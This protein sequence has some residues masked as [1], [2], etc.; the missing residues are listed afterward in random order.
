MISEM[1]SEQ[2]TDELC[3]KIAATRHRKILPGGHAGFRE[4]YLKDQLRPVGERVYPMIQQSTTQTSS[5]GNAA[6]AEEP[7]KSE[8]SFYQRIANP[9]DAAE[10]M[11]TYLYRS[12]MMGVGTKEAGITIALTCLSER[13]SPLEFNRRY[14]IIQGNISM[15]ADY[16]LA[17]FNSLG[18]KHKIIQRDENAAV[19]ELAWE[20]EKTR[21]SF[22]WEDAQ[23]EPFIYGKKKEIKDNYATP[24][25]RMQML[26]ARCVSDGVR[27]VCPQVNSGVYTPEETVDMLGV[28][29][30]S[31]I[32]AEFE[33]EKREPPAAV[34][35]EQRPESSPAPTGRELRREDG[36]ISAINAEVL[37][38][39]SASTQSAAQPTAKQGE[40]THDQL[41][42]IKAYKDAIGYDVEKWQ[43]LLS[44]PKLGG[45]K[46]AK[47]LTEENANRL[48]DF[49]KKESE[50]IQPPTTEVSAA[51]QRDEMSRW[52]DGEL[53]P[54]N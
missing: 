13:I 44:N 1:T 7:E 29:D 26:W 42:R 14:H 23:K 38:R 19:V 17:K 18:G 25:A 30:S 43:R 47:D 36:G 46:S 3:E 41:K 50:K 21:F 16:I 10:Q 9:I 34:T 8:L 2:L 48:I 45:V 15:R 32:D 35:T 31:I 5:A 49:L 37:A 12:A 33:V 20:G 22:T 28:N 39:N 40:V 6:V 4:F 27:A 54:K 52:A 51:Q 24:R 11:G 53:A